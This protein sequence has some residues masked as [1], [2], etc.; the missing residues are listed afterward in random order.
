MDPN[1]QPNNAHTP[2]PVPVPMPTANAPP[3]FLVKTYDMVDDPSTDNVVSWSS[4]NNSFIV[5]DPPEF[6]KFLLPKDSEKLIPIVGNLRMRDSY[7]AKN[8]Y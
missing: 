6:A 7:E 4:T 1:P 5:R 2:Q 8:T 3:P